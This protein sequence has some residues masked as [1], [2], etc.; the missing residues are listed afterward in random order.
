[1]QLEAG[2]EPVDKKKLEASCKGVKPYETSL[3][4]PYSYRGECLTPPLI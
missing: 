4:K 1:M 3:Y 2:E